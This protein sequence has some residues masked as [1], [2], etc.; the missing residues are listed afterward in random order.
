MSGING[1]P[2]QTDRDIDF[3][4]ISSTIDWT[5]SEILLGR[6]VVETFATAFTGRAK[7]SEK[8]DQ[9][10]TKVTN[11]LHLGIKFENYYRGLY[12]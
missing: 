3:F 7:K 12:F 10:R 2:R 9:F 6:G 5:S 11:V 4:D 8:R 1:R